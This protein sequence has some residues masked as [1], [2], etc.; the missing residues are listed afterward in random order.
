M[1]GAIHSARAD[2]SDLGRSKGFARPFWVMMRSVAVPGWGQAYNR[3][4][5]KAVIFGGTESAFIYGIVNDDRRAKDAARL[6]GKYPNESSYWGQVSENYK[7][8]KRDYLWWGSFTLLLSM[9]D[10]FVDAHLR[11]F[12]AEFRQGDSAVLISYEVSF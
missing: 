5:L 1:P 11:G 9:G 4:W 7:A 8:R 6:S 2:S 3:K 12:N 10:A